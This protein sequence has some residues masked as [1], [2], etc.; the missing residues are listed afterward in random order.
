M[1][2]IYGITVCNRPECDNLFQKKSHNAIYCSTECRTIVMNKKILAKYHSDKQKR[3][4]RGKRIC[5]VKNCGTILSRYND[6][7]VCESHKTERLIK[8]LA[9]WGWDEKALRKEWQE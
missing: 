4:N 8:R 1:G 9:S 7:L 3:L 6:E 2:K 5:E